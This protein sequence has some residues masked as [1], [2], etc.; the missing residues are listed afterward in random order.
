LVILFLSTRIVRKEKRREPFLGRR[1]ICPDFFLRFFLF[2]LNFLKVKV[3][4]Y[5]FYIY[6]W[7]RDKTKKIV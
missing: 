6:F 3:Y 7:P 4:I 1:A 2:Y 5:L